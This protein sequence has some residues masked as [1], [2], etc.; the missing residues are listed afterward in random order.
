M[1]TIIVELPDVAEGVAEAEVAEWHVAV[2]DIVE[3]DQILAAV[4]TDKATV[5]IPSTASGRVIRL[6]VAVGETIRVGAPLVVLES[7]TEVEHDPRVDPKPSS[8]PGQGPQVAVAMPGR[9][10]TGRRAGPP[11][12]RHSEEGKTP[13]GSDKRVT[14]RV[15]ESDGG[16]RPSKRSRGLNGEARRANSREIE[17]V[18][19]RLEYARRLSAVARRVPQFS[20]VEEVDV[21]ACEDLRARLNVKWGA[22]KRELTT[23]PFVI[24]A[25]VAALRDHPHMNARYEDARDVVI[26]YDAV[27]IG[28]SF[29]WS[30]I[31]LRDA[32]SLTLWDCEGEMRAGAAGP[33]NGLL[34]SG[35]PAEP[36]ISIASLGDFGGLAM[37]PLIRA[38]E[39]ATIGVNRFSIRPA[40]RENRF[41]ARKIMNLT[42]S[43]DQRIIKPEDAACFIGAIK[44]LLES[45]AELFIEP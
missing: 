41:E 18:G 42:G 9:A 6:G 8:S 44:H 16:G 22:A 25:I 43:F 14:P 28:I 19:E 33:D 27:D 1:R 38:D 10:G 23:L 2:D 5:E 21:T 45:P 36:T 31:V 37:F 32:G 13:G 40:W 29:G 30:A 20:Y 12:G 35:E 7:Q 34:D 15:F 11:D 39:V 26:E 24:R 4:V 3:E 17:I